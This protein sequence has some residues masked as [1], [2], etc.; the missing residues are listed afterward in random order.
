MKK[1]IILLL[2]SHGL[3]A[4]QKFSIRATISEASTHFSYYYKR[5]S[6]YMYGS[7]AASALSPGAD[8]EIKIAPMHLGKINKVLGVYNTS[9]KSL[10]TGINYASH[11]FSARG[12]SIDNDPMYSRMQ[13]RYINVPL[14]WKYN[15]QIFPMNENFHFCFG[16]GLMNSFLLRAHLYEE[17]TDNTRVGGYLVSSELFVDDKDVTKFF[18]K[19]TASFCF[20][21]SI[22]FRRLYIGERAY[23]GSKDQ[24]MK[25]LEP[26]WAVRRDLSIYLS[27][28]E[29]APKLEMGGGFFYIGWRLN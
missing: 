7:N 3:L 2:L 6:Y 1:I 21:M 28:Y 14:M 20:D 23:F 25:D 10:L 27:S 18:V 15:I 8:I 13:T 5:Q 11:T 24:F 29:T 12:F 17:A 22:S 9:Y 19:Y 26:N 16:I 4:Q